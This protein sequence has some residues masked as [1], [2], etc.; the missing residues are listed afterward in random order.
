MRASSTLNRF[1]QPAAEL[2]RIAPVLLFQLSACPN[3]EPLSAFAWPAVA[4]PRSMS[5]D[6]QLTWLVGNFDWM[7]R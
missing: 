2:G 1:N 6:R 4:A 5:H 7:V 3:G